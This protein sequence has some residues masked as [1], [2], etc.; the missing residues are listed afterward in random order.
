[1]D[2]DWKIYKIITPDHRDSRKEKGG[3]GLWENQTSA[4][5][6]K[7]LFTRWHHGIRRLCLP[8]ADRK[9]VTS[10][11]LDLCNMASGQVETKEVVF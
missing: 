5:V 10:S 9:H 8:F 3:K 4:L 7:I 1:M 11:I 2:E 6:T